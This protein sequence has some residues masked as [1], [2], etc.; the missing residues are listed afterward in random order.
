MQWHSY[1]FIIST[2]LRRSIEHLCEKL[3]VDDRRQ[4]VFVEQHAQRSGGDAREPLARPAHVLGAQQQRR[5]QVPGCGLQLVAQDLQC[6][7][8]THTQP[9]NG[10]WSGTTRVGRYQK[11]HSPTHIYPDH[12]TSFIIFL[13]L[14][15]SMAST[16]FISSGHTSQPVLF[17]ATDDNPQLVLCRAS[18]Y[19]VK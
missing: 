5:Q 15:R 12:R 4:E 16:L 7:T 17:R 8:H 13:L 19:E 10:L 1:L 18:K 6:N 14:Q 3:L 11:K 9:F 2:T